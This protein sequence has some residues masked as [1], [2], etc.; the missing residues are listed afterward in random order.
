VADYKVIFPTT[1][2]EFEIEPDGH[3]LAVLSV[4]IFQLKGPNY[5]FEKGCYEKITYKLGKP[6]EAQVLYLDAANASA[7]T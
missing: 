3:L 5:K 2:Q 7:L 6:T 1:A 4:T